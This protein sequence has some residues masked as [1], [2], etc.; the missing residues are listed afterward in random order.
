MKAFTVRYIVNNQVPIAPIKEV[1]VMAES[2]EDAV[3]RV[4][5]VAHQYGEPNATWYEDFTN[6]VIPEQS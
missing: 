1:L 2:Q 6:A 5:E 4:M 3:R